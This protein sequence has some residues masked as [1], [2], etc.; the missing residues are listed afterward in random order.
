MQNLPDMR[1]GADEREESDRKSLV[2]RPL[3]P[4]SLV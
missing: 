2:K 3:P 4:I 1:F